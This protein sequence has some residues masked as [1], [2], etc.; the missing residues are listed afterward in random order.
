MTYS[1]EFSLGYLKSTDR[2]S[3]SG[4]PDTFTATVS[5]TWQGQS[6]DSPWT[7]ESTSTSPQQLPLRVVILAYMHTGSTYLASI[8]QNHPGSFYEFEPLRSLKTEFTL[9]RPRRFLDGSVRYV[10][11][12]YLLS[13]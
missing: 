13:F 1:G 8:L 3:P 11:G 7:Q 12:L 5:S 4:Q 2:K 10:L 9:Q 6:Y